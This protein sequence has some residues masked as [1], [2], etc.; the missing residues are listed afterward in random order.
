[1]D[2]RGILVFSEDQELVLELLTVARSLRADANDPIIVAAIGEAAQ[3]VAE[4][5]LA[6]GADEVLLVKTVADVEAD[7]E[8]MAG[9]LHEVSE[10]V[11]P[12][13]ILFGATRFGADT[14]ARLSQKLKAPCASDCMTLQRADD[15]EIE[16]TRRVYGGRFVA[17]QVLEGSPR[18]ASVP[19]NRF[20]KS[21]PVQA[22][23]TSIKEVGITS[24]VPRVRILGAA[25]R[26]RSAVDVTKAE[27]I[28]AAGRGVKKREDLTMLNTL[29]DTLGGVLAGSRPL[30]GDVDWLPVDSRI[31]LSG[32]T[33]KPNL[34][35]ACGISGQ[36]EHIVGMKDSR[37][38]VAV[39][40]DAKAPIHAEADY[41]VVGDLYEFVPAFIEACTRARQ[42]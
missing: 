18:I 17:M 27:V 19:P 4:T 29:A 1:M 33:V 12:A 35:V 23:K 37:T 30:T 42:S 40:S 25:Q 31:G 14:V 36:I 38:V 7:A 9:I 32:Q 8:R 34:Y 3:T 2:A 41:S 20:A 15:G 26:V 10:M 39:N 13:T 22:P 6:R 28:V 11:S 16:I 5:S 21:D 24:S